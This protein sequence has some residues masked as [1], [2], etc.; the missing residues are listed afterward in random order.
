MRK[1]LALITMACFVLGMAGMVCAEDRMSLSG[2]LQVRAYQNKNKRNQEDNDEDYWQQRLRLQMDIKPTDQVTVFFRADVNEGK[3]GDGTDGTSP[4]N[5]DAKTGPSASGSG[6]PDRI[7][8]IEAAYGRVNTDMYTL[9]VGLHSLKLG[10]G[11][12][13]VP[14]TTGISLRLKTPVDIYLN[15]FKDDEGT[16]LSD[17]EDDQEDRDAYGIQISKGSMRKGTAWGIYGAMLNDDATDDT[18]QVI[19]VFGATDLGPVRIAGEFEHFMGDDGNGIDY[20][21]NNLWLQASMKLSKALEVG[22]VFN[23][24][25]GTDDDSEEMLTEVLTS[26]SGTPGYDNAPA[27]GGMNAGFWPDP[28]SQYAGDGSGTIA[29]GP[30]VNYTVMPKLTVGAHISYL[31]PQ[32][33]DVTDV[34]DNLYLHLGAEYKLNKATNLYLVY[35]SETISGDDLTNDETEQRIVAEFNIKF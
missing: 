18:K 11:T 35:F 21:G 12:A 20:V 22:C 17:E 2:D 28:N 29:I 30:W 24:G 31:T 4:V 13:Y 10:M 23:Y 6:D 33:D 7:W 1:L 15:W 26:P 9:L 8:E 3:W 32:D 25:I 5:F 27:T 14:R 16:S 34:D 19:A